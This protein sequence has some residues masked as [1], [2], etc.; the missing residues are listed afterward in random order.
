MNEVVLTCPGQVCLL[1]VLM[2]TC[3]VWAEAEALSGEW[4]SQSTSSLSPTLGSVANTVIVDQ[5]SCLI[6]NHN[7][8][9]FS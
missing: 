5:E 8:D 7:H 1:Q 9:L 4:F 3:K 2:A 6:P